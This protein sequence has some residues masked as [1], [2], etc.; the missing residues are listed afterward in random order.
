MR[1]YAHAWEKSKTK[2]YIWFKKKINNALH[3]WRWKIHTVFYIQQTSWNRR[4][5]SHSQ[6]PP[7]GLKRIGNSDGIQDYCE[8]DNQDNK[9]TFYSFLT[10]HMPLPLKDKTTEKLLYSFIIPFLCP[11]SFQRLRGFF[12]SFSRNQKRSVLTQVWGQR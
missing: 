2:M 3:R 7:L 6:F 10:H 12:I 8:E 1:T 11:V 5:R 4:R 9:L